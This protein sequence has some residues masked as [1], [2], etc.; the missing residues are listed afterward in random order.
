MFVQT[1]REWRHGQGHTGLRQQQKRMHIVIG[2]V[3][4]EYVL[5]ANRSKKN[6]AQNKLSQTKKGTKGIMRLRALL[7]DHQYYSP[8]LMSVILVNHDLR[9]RPNRC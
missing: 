1:Y 7:R 8:L 5:D 2:V 9:F 4:N 3:E 6:T